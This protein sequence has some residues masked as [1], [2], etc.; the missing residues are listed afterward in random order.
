MTVVRLLKPHRH[1][2][3][4][5]EPGSELELGDAVARWLIAQGVAEA[6]GKQQAN[7]KSRSSG[8]PVRR[9]SCCGGR[10]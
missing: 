2:G 1:G 7:A 4:R 6:T 9:A 8:P 5:L 3:R 10:W